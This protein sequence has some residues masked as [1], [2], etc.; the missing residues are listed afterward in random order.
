MLR[1]VF[2]CYC[3]C[4]N[5]LELFVYFNTL[6]SFPLHSYIQMRA[7]IFN[8]NQQ[9]SQNKNIFTNN[10]ANQN[11]IFTSNQT[12]STNQN[13]Q[14][15][16]SNNQNTN[17]NTNQNPINILNRPNINISAQG[18]SSSLPSNLGSNKPLVADCLQ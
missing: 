1:F 11:N 3:F 10:Q 18:S 4:A 16:Q 15:V 17:Q 7:N 12:S 5:Y 13:N 2:I 9:T 14:N 6:I 8:N